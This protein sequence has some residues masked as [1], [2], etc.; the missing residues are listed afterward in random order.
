MADK[1]ILITRLWADACA[2]PDRD[3]YVS[4][5]ALSTVWGDDPEQDTAIPQPRLDSLSQI[6]RAAHMTVPDIVKAAGL[7]QT[8][9]SN[10]FAI[11]MRTVSDWCRGLRTP[12]DYVRLLLQ[13][14]LGLLPDIQVVPH[15]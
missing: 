1:T 6:H 15:D 7:T 14:Q 8:A 12:P 11:P 10:R 3:A 5:W 4:D 2:S 9:L 13:L